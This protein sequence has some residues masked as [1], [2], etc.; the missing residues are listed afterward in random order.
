MKQFHPNEDWALGMMFG[1]AIGDAMGAPI[2]FKS[3]V[4]LKTMF[5]NTSPAAHI[6]CPKVSSPM[7]RRWPWQW[8]TRSLK[9]MI[10][11]QL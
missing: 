2:E 5:V 4:S 11:I 7:I 10:S 1:M 8:L 9:L 3:R 6:K